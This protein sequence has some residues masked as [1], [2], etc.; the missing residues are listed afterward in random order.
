MKLNP[1]SGFGITAGCEL[2]L[3]AG[4]DAEG[5]VGGMERDAAVAP[6]AFAFT[7]GREFGESA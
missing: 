1:P 5:P 6:S 2:I 4:R 3:A 7:S